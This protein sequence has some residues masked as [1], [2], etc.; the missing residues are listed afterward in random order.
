MSPSWLPD[1]LAEIADVIGVDAALRLADAR[2][3]GRVTIPSRAPE[4]HWLVGLIGREAADQLCAHFRTL[5]PE[6]AARG[7][8]L[9]LPRGPTGTLAS[10]RR[11][12]AQAMADGASAEAAARHAGMSRRT[13]YRMKKRRTGDDKQGRLF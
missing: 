1:T 8:E 2:G 5:S 13:A 6:G 9:D 10:A 3:G 4:G 12:I 11:R 7:V